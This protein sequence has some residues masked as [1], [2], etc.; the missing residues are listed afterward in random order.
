[1]V[2]SGELG[3]FDTRNISPQIF[4]ERACSSFR[5]IGVVGRVETV[6]DEH[7]GYHVL[8]AVVSVGEIVHGFVLFVDDADA[9]FVGTAG[10]GFD[11]FCGFALF[12]ELGVD[13]FGGFDGGLGVELGW[14]RPL[15]L[16]EVEGVEV[17]IPGY[18]TLKR[19]F[20]IT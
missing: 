18:E 9:S 1:M 20:S 17:D 10:D 3:V 19:M 6:E 5:A 7:S 11:V 14:E 12:C 4:D 2:G 15:A 16:V 8:Y 13:F